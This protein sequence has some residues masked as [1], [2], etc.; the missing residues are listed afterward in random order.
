MEKPN[1]RVYK[2]EADENGISLFWEKTDEVVFGI[3]TIILGDIKYDAETDEFIQENYAFS[4]LLD[5]DENK[6]FL[7]ELLMSV[8]NELKVVE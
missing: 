7:T 5:A 2:I 1:A 4:G 6:S 3:Y 8:V